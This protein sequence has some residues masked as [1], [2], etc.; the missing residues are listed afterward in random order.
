MAK[1]QALAYPGDF[2]HAVRTLSRGGV[3]ERRAAR[4][5]TPISMIILRKRTFTLID[6]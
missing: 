2:D 1:A 5:L 4:Q 6:G 3:V